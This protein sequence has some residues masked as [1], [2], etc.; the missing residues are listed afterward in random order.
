MHDCSLDLIQ[1]T[2]V[3]HGRSPL[4]RV[5]CWQA[6]DGCTLEQVACC[7][8]D[9]DQGDLPQSR[10]TQTGYKLLLGL[11]AVVFHSAE[12]HVN[13]GHFSILYRIC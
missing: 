7:Q 2:T 9:C 3:S 12:I 6:C 5:H 1:I 4:E 8:G 13:T 11:P 10:S